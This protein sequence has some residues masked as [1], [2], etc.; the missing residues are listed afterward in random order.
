HRIRARPP[1]G[2]A[3]DPRPADRLPARALRLARVDHR[4]YLRRPAR[5]PRPRPARP[6]IVKP[7]VDWF[8]LSPVLALLAASGVCLLVAVSVPARAR[9]PFS[10]WV[11]A[12]GYVG[13]F[14]AA[15]ILYGHSADGHGVIADAIRRD[16]FGA[17]AAIFVAGA[18]LAA[19][20]VSYAA[21]E[22]AEHVAEYYALLAAAGA[23]M[24][25]LASANNLMT[26]FLSLEWFS[27]CLYVLCSIHLEMVTSL[28]AGLKYLIV[29]GF[30]SAF[31]LFGSALVYG[32][33]GHLDF[34]GIAQATAAQHLSR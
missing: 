34:A 22:R 16:R 18:G 2:G 5:V 30:G 4:P 17:L 31:L 25:F 24:I 19:V 7:P 26:L 10:A 13:A 9:R 6:M 14:I 23:G 29:G 1:P 8:A 12:L 21:R 20:G 32:A 33:T 28:E 15:A 3:R 27:L 11:C